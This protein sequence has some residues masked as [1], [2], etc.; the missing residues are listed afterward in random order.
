LK[1]TILELY[2]LQKEVARL[3]QLLKKQ[4]NANNM[5]AS[6]NIRVTVWF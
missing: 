1:I 5:N 3:K 4:P 6:K 2:A